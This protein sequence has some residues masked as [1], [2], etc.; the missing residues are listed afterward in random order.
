MI[1]AIAINFLGYLLKAFSLTIN[2]FYTTLKA[3][4]SFSGIDGLVVEA[5]AEVFWSY[6]ARQNFEDVHDSYGGDIFD[7]LFSSRQ[8]ANMQLIENLWLR[9]ILNPQSQ[10]RQMGRDVS[11]NV[12]DLHTVGVRQKIAYF[13]PLIEKLVMVWRSVLRN[14]PKIKGPFI[15]SENIF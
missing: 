9:S 3:G 6:L 15:N 13:V 11:R 1:F 7:K 8:E 5:L 10:L 4:L 2:W 14:W 12:D